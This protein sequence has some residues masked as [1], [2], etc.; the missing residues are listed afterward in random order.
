MKACWGA[1]GD[2]EIMRR[3]GIAAA[4]V[5]AASVLSSGV[6]TAIPDNP[7][8]SANGWNVAAYGATCSFAFNVA[9]QV[10]PSSVGG[11]GT[12]TAYSPATGTNY[13]VTCHDARGQSE[14]AVAYEC[15]ILSQRG[16]VIYLWQ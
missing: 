15:T 11:Q 12:V 5:A 2:G 9:N 4:V 1:G 10:R 7:C 3:V 13:S 8:G 14:Y 6:A 16:G